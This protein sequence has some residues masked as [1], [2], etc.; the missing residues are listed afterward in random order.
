M[1]QPP[2]PWRVNDVVLHDA[3]RDEFRSAIGAVM[4]AADSPGDN[5]VALVRQLRSDMH[6]TDGFDR[7]GI[8]SRLEA[9]RAPTRAT[10][11]RSRD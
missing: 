9:V 2:S 3:L 7:H 4:A 1:S 6:S 8:A 11:E 10:P 5:V